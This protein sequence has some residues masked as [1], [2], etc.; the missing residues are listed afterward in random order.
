MSAVTTENGVVKIKVQLEIVHED[1]DLLEKVKSD[2]GSVQKQTGGAQQD[3]QSL[4]ESELQNIDQGTL[5]KALGFG[6]DDLALLTNMAKNP[7]AAFAT[8]APVIGP[9]L[10]T[11]AVLKIIADWMVGPGG[12]LDRRFKRDIPMEIEQ[13]L[14]RQQQKS[15]QIGL[16][17]VV[18]TTRAGWRNING[19][20]ENANT[21][22]Q[23]REGNRL[24]EIGLSEKA[25]GWRP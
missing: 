19:A 1:L 16:R 11:P 4:L 25:M 12:P 21:F 3:A 23:I 18:I 10:M 13:F 14:T 2:L 24:A 15:T 8:L 9:L 20:S 17:Q 7:S 6:T 5:A 22:R